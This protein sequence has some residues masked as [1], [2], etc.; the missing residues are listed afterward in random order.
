[1]TF[2][3]HVPVTAALE[4]N[5]VRDAMHTPIQSCAHDTPWAEVAA[6]MAKRHIHAVVVDRADDADDGWGVVSALDLVEAAASGAALTAG[7]AEA[8]EA[9][10]VHADEPLRRG[11]QLMAEHEVTHLVVVDDRGDRPVGVLSTFDVARVYAE[12]QP[13]RLPHSLRGPVVV[14]VDGSPHGEDAVALGRCLGDALCERLVLVHVVEPT[15]LGRGAVE[16]GASAHERGR[17]ILREA[18]ADL[19]KPE[20]D[21]KLIEG[22]TASRGLHDLAGDSDAGLIVL[23]SSV[24]GPLG[25]ILIGSVAE[26]LLTWSPCT[27]AVA[28]AGYA[29]SAERHAL[30]LIGVG[31][32]DT[33]ESRLALDF[34]ITIAQTTGAALRLW[35]V[36]A[37]T[38]AEGA[39]P[40]RSADFTNYIHGIARRELGHGGARVPEELRVTTK[41]MEGSA[42]DQIAQDAIREHV[43]LVVVG[44]RG[45]PGRERPDRQHGAQADAH[46]ALPRR[47]SAASPVREWRSGRC[48]ELRTPPAVPAG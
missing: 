25:R 21:R 40:D 44:S 7:E 2:L 35:R 17:S 36:V 39:H 10:T 15:P 13:S 33:P 38:G 18:G 45:R 16:L 12:H 46:C 30:R 48:G 27:V 31:Y 19:V 29:T 4:R 43:D 47:R 23:G 37:P 8:T 42:A 28:P 1:M 32:D 34:A 20:T 9:V 6:A 3:S 26:D 22:V 14:G 5:C 24:H 11:A 41:V